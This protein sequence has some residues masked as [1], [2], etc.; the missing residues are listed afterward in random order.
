MILRRKFLC[1]QLHK[2]LAEPQHIPLIGFCHILRQKRSVAGARRHEDNISF[3]QTI[4]ICAH[5]IFR[6]TVIG[7]VE[8]F[9]EGVAVKGKLGIGK[10]HIPVGLHIGV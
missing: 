5:Q 2:F 8:Q 10:A 7:T 4:A 1:K 6:S 3:L 9:I